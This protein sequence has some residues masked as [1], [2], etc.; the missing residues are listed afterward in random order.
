VSNTDPSATPQISDLLDSRAVVIDALERRRRA[1]WEHPGGTL[2][3]VSATIVPGQ[4]RANAA[5][6]ASWVQVTVSRTGRDVV[7]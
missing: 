5:H 4:T 6:S 2:R 1:S 7:A 3:A